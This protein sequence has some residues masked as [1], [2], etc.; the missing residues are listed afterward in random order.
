[1]RGAGDGCRSKED[2]DTIKHLRAFPGGGG[3]LRVA[4][5]AVAGGVRAGRA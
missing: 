4:H 3:C 1:M 5:A 2:D